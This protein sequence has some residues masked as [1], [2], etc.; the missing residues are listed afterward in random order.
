[1]QG[2]V[3][4]MIVRQRRNEFRRKKVLQSELHCRAYK[5]FPPCLIPTGDSQLGKRTQGS[6]IAISVFFTTD[7]TG[8]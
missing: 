3:T 8:D 5:L 7:F 4:E 2:R 6:F 1:M